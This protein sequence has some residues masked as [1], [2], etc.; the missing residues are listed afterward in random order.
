SSKLDLLV[1]VRYS[2]PLPAPPCP[3]KL[4]QIPT[5]PSRYAR[6]EFLNAIAND[7]PLP[8]IVDAECGMPLDLGRWECLWEEG[9]DDS[10]LNPDPHDLPLLDPKDKFLLGDPSSTPGGPYTNGAATPGT[11]APLPVH[12]PWLRKTEYISREGVQRGSGTQEPKLTPQANIDISH[13]AQLSTIESS[14]AANNSPTSNTEFDLK[15]LR[16]PNKPD[17]TAVESYE[18]FPDAEI[19]ANA[20][21][22]FRFSERPGERSV[23]VEDPRLDCAILRPMESDGDH[24]L[25]YYLTQTDEAAT[26]FKASR[27]NPPTLTPTSTNANPLAFLDS[28]DQPETNPNATV[29]HFVRDYETVKVEQEVPNEFLLVLD[30]GS[31][32]VEGD[33]V[34]VED[35]SAKGKRK[36]G[37]YYKNIERKMIL[38]KK[39]VNTHEAYLDKW[40]VVKLTHTRMSAEEAEER[41]EVLAEVMDPTYLLGRD[42][43]ADGDADAEGEG[44]GVGVFGI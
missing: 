14:F 38:K 9:A 24:F 4:L 11:S 33:G 42:V 31:T 39:R 29:F 32:K 36:K 43:D 2:N 13:A 15:S 25:A 17:V 10:A 3:P 19:W 7:T 1:R 41:E 8:M 30:D 16:H 28:D 37:A 22:L 20:Y 26:S 40:E 12:V 35:D 34:K 6:P 23:E 44:V 5:N 18:I 21:D 27:S